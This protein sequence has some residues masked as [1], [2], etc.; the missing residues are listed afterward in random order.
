MSGRFKGNREYLIFQFVR[1]VDHFIRPAQDKL[2]IPSL[3]HRD[4]LRRRI[5]IAL[6]A[7]LVV[8]HIDEQNLARIE[9]V[10][11]PEQPIGSTRAMRTW[12]TTKGN[13]PTGKSQISHVV[14]DSTWEIYAANLFE[15]S[16]LVSAYARNDHLGFQIHCLWNGSRRRF[17]P[18]F[19]VRLSNG[20][21]PVLEIKG[22]D[23][24]QNV[25]KRQALKQWVAAVNAKGG[26]GTWCWDVAF[27]PA[28]VHDIVQRHG[29]AAGAPAAAL[30]LS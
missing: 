12:Y 4:G 9:P 6:N 29:S 2:D 5:L 11:D 30:V 21:T 8:Q 17:V 25:A 1:L 13:Q 20:V 24:P 10:F 27:E 7:D 22:E 18:D 26:F 19:I 15:N 23:S 14:G 16:D 3:F 28:Q